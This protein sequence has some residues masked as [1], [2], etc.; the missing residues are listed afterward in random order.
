VF[1]AR[2]GYSI[3]I[4]T[5]PTFPLGSVVIVANAGTSTYPGISEYQPPRDLPKGNT[6]YWRVASL[7]AVTYGTS[8]P[9]VADPF[10]GANPPLEPKLLAPMTNKLEPTT[11]PT[12]IW[13]PSVIPGGTTFDH[14]EIQVAQDS[15][16]TY[17]IA[18]TQPTTADE[19]DTSYTI[20]SGLLNP[21]KIYYWRVRAC[22]AD[23]VPDT[24]CSSW[25]LG[26]YFR[27]SVAV[28][29]PTAGS[30]DAITN[31]LRPIFSWDAANAATSYSTFMTR[32]T[33]CVTPITGA[34]L[35]A[36]NRVYQ[37]PTLLP[38]TT[39]LWC[40]RT[41]NVTFGPSAWYSETYL[42]P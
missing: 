28:P 29:A 39:Y 2:R 41:N 6:L 12:F 7:N 16:F 13:A 5:K 30:P 20:A 25:S 17:L 21:A 4:S 9:T 1:G 37:P 32:K 34:T 33:T 3:Q 8:L 26:T 42:T 36:T 24:Q 14:Y 31:P 10:I 15:K 27:T 11:T 18:L 40:V 22:N 35:S 19:Y 38:A 23:P